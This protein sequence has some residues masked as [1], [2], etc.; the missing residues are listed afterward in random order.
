MQAPRPGSLEEGRDDAAP[1]TGKLGDSPGAGQPAEAQPEA[2]AVLEE[3]STERPAGN[4]ARLP[5]SVSEDPIGPAGGRPA[6]AFSPAAYPRERSDRSAKIEAG[7][8][9]GLFRWII[10][11]FVGVVVAGGS[12]YGSKSI[13][14]IF[15]S[16]DV[17]PGEDKFVEDKILGEHGMEIQDWFNQDHTRNVGAL[18]ESEAMALAD[19]LLALGA[20]RVLAF[21]HGTEDL[22]IE[23]PDDK[24]MRKALFDWQADFN[25]EHHQKI[26]ED[27]GQRY[28]LIRLGS[29]LH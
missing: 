16:A 14:R 18:N 13:A 4:G 28:L 10:L 3:G 7:R 22:A 1:Q 20:K 15:E 29:V 11:L 24:P 23:L 5:R 6:S 2:I 26:W 17:K 27:E 9:G 12:L 19:Q 21:G 8:K 25:K